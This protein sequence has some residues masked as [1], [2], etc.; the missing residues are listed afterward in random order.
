VVEAVAGENISVAKGLT[1]FVR[2]SLSG[3][4]GGQVARVTGSQSS[5]VLRSMSLGDALLISPP[6]TGVIERGAAVRVLLLAHNDS[7]E[8]PV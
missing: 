7:R 2:C 5:G 6:G 4:P 1:E 3:L 8:Q